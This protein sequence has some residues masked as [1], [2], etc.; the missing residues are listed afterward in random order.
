VIQRNNKKRNLY[1]FVKTRL[2][3]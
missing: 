2:I 1:W 3:R